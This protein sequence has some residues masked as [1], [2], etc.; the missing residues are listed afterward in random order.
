VFL[1]AVNRVGI[2]GPLHLF[3]KSKIVDPWG[4]VIAEA[5]KNQEDCLIATFDLEQVTKAREY[6][7]YL[8]NRR[9][10]TYSELVTPCL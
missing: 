3:G 7:A 9:P 6:Y 8:E 1:C 5:A 2:E 4:E 10:E